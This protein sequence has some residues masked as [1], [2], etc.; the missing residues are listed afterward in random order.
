MMDLALSENL[1]LQQRHNIANRQNVPVDFMDQITSRLRSS[2]LIQSLRGRKGGFLL[3]KKP[4]EISL[5]DIFISVED[6][7]YP[8][9][10]V[11]KEPC[12]LDHS[13]VSIKVWN[14]MYTEI[15]ALLSKKTLADVIEGKELPALNESTHHPLGCDSCNRP[16]PLPVKPILL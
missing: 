9:K 6:N 8:V 7:F 1:G 4:S 15:R 10:C 16:H 2:G 3:N 14:E 5:F 11:D 12:D 13:C